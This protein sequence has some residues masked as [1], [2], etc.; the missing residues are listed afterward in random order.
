M[1]DRS[2]VNFTAMVMAA[3]TGSRMRSEEKKQ[4]MALLDEPVIL[5]SL[6]AFQNDP[7]IRSIVVVTAKEDIDRVLKICF[8]NGIRK[9]VNIVEGGSARFRSVANGLRVVPEDTDYVLIH[10]AARPLIDSAL[11][12]RIC[13]SAVMY[14]ACVAAVPVKDTIKQADENGFTL[15]TIDRA[16][17]WSVQTPQAFSFDLIRRAYD[18]LFA[19]IEAY[20]PD[21]SKITDDAVIVENMSDCRVRMVMGDYK[22]LKITTPED[23]V[24]AEAFLK[25]KMQGENEEE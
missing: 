10:D 13:D 6:R 25:E 14:R 17:L 2:N 19:T 12:G 4:F 22:N 5:Y 16:G 7:R 20:H 9:L 24:L 23:M 8:S 15:R 1:E 3:G 11:I 21:E 18:K